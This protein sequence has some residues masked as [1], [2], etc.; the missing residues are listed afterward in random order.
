MRRDVVRRLVRGRDLAAVAVRAREAFGEEA[1]VLGTRVLRRGRD[2]LVEVVAAAASDVERFERRLTAAPLP[3]AP[4]RPTVVALVG[5][6]GA[7]K[8]T[9]VAKLAVGAAAF[10]ARRVGLLTLDTWRAGAVAQLDAYATV[11]ALPLEV[12]YDARDA[13]Q[14]L[15]R[16]TGSGCDVVLVD[17]PGRGPRDGAAGADDDWRAMLAAL[18]PDEVHLT[19]PATLR[20]RVADAVRERHEPLGVTH[21]LLTQLDEAPDEEGVTELAARLALP[22]R[23]VSD[24]QAVPHDLHPGVPRLLQTLGG[25]AG[26][27][28]APAPARGTPA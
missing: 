5:P 15:A 28:P 17:T 6:S 9:T 3:T 16:L 2:P 10:A 20:E 19:L 18:A 7:G 1:V 14:G 25:F 21:A 27:L 26:V 8:T 13:A 23:W 22:V 24:G 12:A 4:G 11:A